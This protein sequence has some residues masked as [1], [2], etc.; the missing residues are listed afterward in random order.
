MAIAACTAGGELQHA[1][2]EKLGGKRDCF[3]NME[4]ELEDGCS[5]RA[6]C[7]PKSSEPVFNGKYAV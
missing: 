4:F 3:A 2:V 6:H 7:V 5:L 1:E